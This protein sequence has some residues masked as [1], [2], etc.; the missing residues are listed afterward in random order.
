MFFGLCNSPSS[1]QSFINEV[2]HNFLN[3]FCTVYLDDILIYSDNKKE[4]NEHVHLILISLQEFGFYMNIEKCVFKIWKVLYLSFFIG[5]NSICMDSQ[6]IV[7]ITDWLTL[8]KLKQIQSFLEFANFYCCFIVNFF[9]IAK[10]LT[11]LIQKDTLFSWT[12][13]C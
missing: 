7:T 8:I 11:Y 10:S 12:S 3:V 1:F 2:F 6:K 5:V 9:K 4:H 13:E